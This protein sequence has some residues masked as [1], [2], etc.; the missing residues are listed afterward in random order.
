MRDTVIENVE[1]DGTFQVAAN[2]PIPEYLE[3]LTSRYDSEQK[4]LCAKEAIPAFTRVFT[5]FGTVVPNEQATAHAL[6][7]GGGLFLESLEETS[8]DQYTDHSCDP[9]CRVVFVVDNEGTTKEVFMESL[10][11]IHIGEAITFDYCST[12]FDMR[13][14]ADVCDFSCSCL[15]KNCRKEIYGFNGLSFEEQSKLI[16]TGLITSPFLLDEFNKIQKKQHQ[17]SETM[18][19]FNSAFR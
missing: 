5:F 19:S 12:E 3:V 4:T 15:A 18:Q 9:S 16:S 8:F 14:Q 11:V 2:P 13:T 6:N 10:R 17:V 7:I 1:R